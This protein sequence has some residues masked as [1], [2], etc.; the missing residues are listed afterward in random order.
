MARNIGLVDYFIRH[1][2]DKNYLGNDLL[3]TYNDAA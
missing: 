3:D 2:K 1:P